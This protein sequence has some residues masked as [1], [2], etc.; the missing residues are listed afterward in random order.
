MS[1]VGLSRVDLEMAI[2][3]S[4]R[5]PL[6]HFMNRHAHG[7]C[8]LHTLNLT[9]LVCGDAELIAD[10]LNRVFPHLK[11][12]LAYNWRDEQGVTTIEDWKYVRK[13]LRCYQG[14]WDST[15]I[16]LPHVPLPSLN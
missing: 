14:R 8:S 3:A 6:P 1:R 11:F 4:A 16:E 13:K 12:F 9:T 10:F 5:E 15:W 2:D 7:P